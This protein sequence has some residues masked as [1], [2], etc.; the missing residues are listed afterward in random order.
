VVDEE[1]K[2]AFETDR[3][4]RHL[5]PYLFENKDNE[6]SEKELEDDSEEEK[7]LELVNKAVD[8]LKKLTKTEKNKKLLKR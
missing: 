7:R 4:L 5:K 6:E 8:R 3:R 2:R 1:R